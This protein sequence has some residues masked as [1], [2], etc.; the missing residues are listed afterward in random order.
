M[1]GISADELKRKF[2]HDLQLLLEM[3]T[4]LK[5]NYDSLEHLAKYIPLISEP[6]KYRE[7]QYVKSGKWEL[8]YMGILISLVQKLAKKVDY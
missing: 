3:A 8:P 6:H 4:Q 2:G 1:Q 7:F 5:L